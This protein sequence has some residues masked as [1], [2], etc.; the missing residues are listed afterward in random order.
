MWST[1]KSLSGGLV[2][3]L[4]TP[5]TSIRGNSRTLEVVGGTVGQANFAECQGKYVRIYMLTSHAGFGSGTSE[6]KLKHFVY[7]TSRVVGSVTG[8]IGILLPEI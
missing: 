4:F 5:V 1:P 6:F 7:R 3:I 8:S 2:P